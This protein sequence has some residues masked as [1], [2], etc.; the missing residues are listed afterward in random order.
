VSDARRDTEFL[1]R[2]LRAMGIEVEHET[3]STWARGRLALSSA[4]FES[5]AEPIRVPAAVFYTLGH[6]RLKFCQPRI[7]FD[8][9]AL[10][11][12]G[13]E[14]SAEL[15][16]ALRLAW[17]RLHR[18][19]AS[20]QRHFSRLG[21][22]EVSNHGTRLQLIPAAGARSHWEVRSSDELQVPSIGAL[23]DQ[24]ACEPGQRRFR[25]LR[26]LESS[27]ELDLALEAAVRAGAERRGAL[28][29]SGAGQPR[30]P[31]ARA[32]VLA[33]ASDEGL[34]AELAAEL[35]ARE[36]A[37]ALHRDPERALSAFARHSFDAVLV[38]SRL[39]RA[40]GLEV[41]LRVREIPGVEDLPVALIDSRESAQHREAASRLGLACY[42][43][44]P[45]AGAEL[46]ALLDELLQLTRRRFRRFRARL[47]ARTAASENEDR[48]EQIARGGLCLRS[49]RPLRVGEDETYSI[50]LPAPH[51]PVR[52]SGR[53]VARIGVPGS[54]TQLAGVRLT[55]FERGSE[56][57]WIRVIEALARREAAKLR[58]GRG[59]DSSG[60]GG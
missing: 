6:G 17:Q 33:L 23:E 59:G 56:E 47:A 58:P 45:L 14:T 38:E 57:R 27:T 4:P 20:A 52:M 9:P 3:G 37:V 15:E 46:S 7:F 25:P 21:T 19:L 28:P 54:T 32:R 18:D 16:Q 42:R 1:V 35:P 39:A 44:K 60:A 50:A 10:E 2:R 41:A 30:P 48:T 34:L 55:G 8:L 31:R 29:R 11:I 12:A 51:E 24:P 26:G 53:V 13:C 43:V 49:A 5:L 36:I 40:D 22:L